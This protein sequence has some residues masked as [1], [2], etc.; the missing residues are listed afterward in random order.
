MGR[1]LINSGGNSQWQVIESVALSLAGKLF[2]RRK[3]GHQT[4]MA[5]A[6]QTKNTCSIRLLLIENAKIACSDN[7]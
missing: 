2:A 5:S 6:G 4:M 7:V 3:T 1:T